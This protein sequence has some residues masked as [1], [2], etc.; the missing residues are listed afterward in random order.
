LLK[1]VDGHGIV[2]TV[3][4]E[5]VRSNVLTWSAAGRID[6]ELACSFHC[7]STISFME[8]IQQAVKGREANAAEGEP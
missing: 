5:A 6:S 1:K 7:S 3:P 4:N 8:E 2:T